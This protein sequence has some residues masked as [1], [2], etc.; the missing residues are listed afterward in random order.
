MIEYALAIA[1]VAVVLIVVIT[2]FGGKVNTF[3]SGAE[4]HLT[5]PD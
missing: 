1:L 3:F 4:D 5:V 2:S